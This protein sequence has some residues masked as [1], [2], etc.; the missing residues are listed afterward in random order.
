M[1]PL[2][3]RLQ[4]ILAGRLQERQGVVVVPVQEFKRWLDSA[5]HRAGIGHVTSHHHTFAT[6]MLDYSVPLNYVLYLLGHRDPKMTQRY[7]NPRPK[8]HRRAIEML[9]REDEAES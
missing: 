8:C 7:H 1:I 6:L 2:T 3:A 5:G 4:A 9:H